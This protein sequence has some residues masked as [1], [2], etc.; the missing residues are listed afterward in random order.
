[1]VLKSTWKAWEMMACFSKKKRENDG[2]SASKDGT[3]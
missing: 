2:L 1:M 3:A